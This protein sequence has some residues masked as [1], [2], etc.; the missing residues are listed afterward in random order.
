MGRN[1]M[2]HLRMALAF[3]IRRSVLPSSGPLVQTAAL[4]VHGT[5]VGRRGPLSSHEVDE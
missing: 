2:A 1:L 5:A 3:R 4:L